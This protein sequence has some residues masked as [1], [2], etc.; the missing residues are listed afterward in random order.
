MSGARTVTGRA[1]KHQNRRARAAAVKLDRVVC[2]PQWALG[3]V[4]RP[5]RK[6]RVD[7]VALCLPISG[8]RHAFFK[9]G[10]T[11]PQAFHL[12]W[13]DDRPSL[14]PLHDG[15]EAWRLMEA[16]GRGEY[17]ELPPMIRWRIEIE[18]VPGRYMGSGGSSGARGAGTGWTG[19]T[20]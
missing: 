7:E 1:Q 19:S 3:S 16:R 13:S 9:R 15:I 6:Q 11:G 18:S 12:S 2:P 10:L 14:T 20:P 5:R 4:H 8:F 17:P